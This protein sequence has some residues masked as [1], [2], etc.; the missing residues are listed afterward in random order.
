MAEVAFLATRGPLSMFPS[1]ELYNHI[2]ER[3]YKFKKYARMV[4]LGKAVLIR[5]VTPSVMIGD[6]PFPLLPND[7]NPLFRLNHLDMAKL[8]WDSP[9][10]E[11]RGVMEE[12][13]IAE[14]WQQG[15]VQGLARM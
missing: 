6:D 13:G 14:I 11:T 8:Y 10:G 4:L 2:T 1:D 15:R 3:I 7:M 12:T 5:T 9:I